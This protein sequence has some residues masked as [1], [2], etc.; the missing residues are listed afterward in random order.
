MPC[1][2]VLFPDVSLC[3]SPP[4]CCCVLSLLLLLLLLLLYLTQIEISDELAAEMEALAA[5]TAV[6]PRDIDAIV[7]DLL[8]DDDDLEEAEVPLYARRNPVV[9][10]AAVTGATISR[11]SSTSSN[12]SS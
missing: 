5:G 11:S 1:L 3:R 9:A 4:C 2:C 10:A 12:T 6:D 8:A 7:K